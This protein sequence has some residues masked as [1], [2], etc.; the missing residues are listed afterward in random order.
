MCGL[1]GFTGN[2]KSRLN[3]KFIKLIMKANDKRGGHSTGYYDGEFFT[4]VVGKSPLLVGEMNKL[5]TNVFIGHTRYATHGAVSCENQHPF[6][7]NNIVGAHNGVVRNY[8]EV[9]EEFNQKETTVDSQMIFKCLNHLQDSKEKHN[10][11]GMFSG[12]LATIYTDT[13]TG[14][15]Y[16]YRSGN[17]LF[18]GRDKH[19]SAYFSSLEEPLKA[20]GLKGIFEL[21]EE[22]IYVWAGA[23]IIERIDIDIDPVYSVNNASTMNWYDYGN[24]NYNSHFS[25]PKKKKKPVYNTLKRGVY[26][27][28]TDAFDMD[29]D[30][31]KDMRKNQKNL[32]S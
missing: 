27:G 18:V 7:Y 8:V 32:F 3:R 12:T 9:G 23:K 20:C 24:Y 15:V 6:Q 22:R 4:K 29:T 17:P 31:E 10:I 11:L 21:K 13:K 2:K 16:T 25:T 26:S 14:L 30:N 1:I 19:G 5:K 28:I